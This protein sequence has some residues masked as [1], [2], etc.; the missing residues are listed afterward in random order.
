MNSRDVIRFGIGI[1]GVG[2]IYKV[3]TH[4]F[5]EETKVISPKSKISQILDTLKSCLMI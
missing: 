1:I 5:K 2:L 4:T 3:L